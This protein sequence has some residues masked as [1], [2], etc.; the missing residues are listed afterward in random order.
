MS[1]KM[2]GTVRVSGADDGGTSVRT[3]YA[4]VTGKAADLKVDTSGE[5]PTAGRRADDHQG[6]RQGQPRGLV[7]HADSISPSHRSERD[8][9]DICRSPCLDNVNLT[10]WAGEVVGLLGEN[11]PAS[12]R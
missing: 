11:V 8:Y 1:G 12:Q 7:S 9:Q 4:I 2:Y 5:R 6:Q 10:L 3:L